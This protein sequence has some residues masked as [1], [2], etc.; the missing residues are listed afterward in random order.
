MLSALSLDEATIA[1][2]LPNKRRIYIQPINN[3]LINNTSPKELA[4]LINEMMK[5]YILL[6]IRSQQAELEA[7]H[8][9]TY[10]VFFMMRLLSETLRECED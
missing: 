3:S 8:E 10:E 5:E 2:F 6:L 9:R 4:D 1:C 7:M